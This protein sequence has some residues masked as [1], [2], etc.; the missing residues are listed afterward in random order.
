MVAMVCRV[1][2]IVYLKT[3]QKKT[4]PAANLSQSFAVAEYKSGPTV[5]VLH[6]VL[7]RWFFLYAI[8]ME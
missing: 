1:I 3:R 8:L 2:M 5:E 7:M 6:A 4:R